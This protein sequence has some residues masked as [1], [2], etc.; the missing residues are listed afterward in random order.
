MDR[1][2]IRL[3]GIS[4]TKTSNDV[5]RWAFDLTQL[6]PINSELIE[7]ENGEWEIL[8]ES[9]IGMIHFLSFIKKNT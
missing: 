9:V 5:E 4:V 3:L 7:E 6:I 8:F 2:R 1:R